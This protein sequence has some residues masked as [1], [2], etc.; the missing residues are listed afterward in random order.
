LH[1]IA[2]FAAEAYAAGVTRSGG[3]LT[4]RVQAGARAAVALAIEHHDDPRVL[5][6]TLDL[7]RLEGLWARLFKRREDLIRHH[8]GLVTDAWRA[9]LTAELINDA[10]AAVRRD[11]GSDD[12]DR[13]KTAV[14]A[15]VAAMTAS[16]PN[17][18]AWTQLRQA[19]RDALAAGQAE[20]AAAASVLHADRTQQPQPDWGTEYDD[21]LAVATAR[22]Q[23]WADTDTWASKLVGR[24]AHDLGRALTSQGVD[25][26]DDELRQAANHSARTGD[27][28]AIGF[29]VDWA[30][31]AAAGAGALAAYVARGQTLL[32]WTTAGDGR[33]CVA[34]EDNEANGPYTPIEFP[35][36]PQH[37]GCRC[38]PTPV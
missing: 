20:G 35:A 36:L 9:I 6:L 11:D 24:I 16:L 5:E 26:S 23:L 31:T 38:Q 19:I 29:T 33:V 8:T 28:P 1:P 22:P 2:E 17:R 27:L 12:P 3:L 25:A 30:M 18:P 14:L 7:G 13:W 15:A 37:P 4:E 21:A 32:N 10:I 34:C